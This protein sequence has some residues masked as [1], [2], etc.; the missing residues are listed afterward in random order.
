[1]GLADR[2]YRSLVVA[3]GSAVAIL[4]VIEYWD[5]DGARSLLSIL[6]IGALAFI[7][8]YL[9]YWIEDKLTQPK[10]K[11]INAFGE[12]L[13]LVTTKKWGPNGIEAEDVMRVRSDSYDGDCVNLAVSFNPRKVDRLEI[14]PI[15]RPLADSDG[16]VKDAERL[17]NEP[18]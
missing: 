17:A 6:G 8:T 1:M 13:L 3:F 18:F 10:K 9:P 14:S 7:L 12:V 2:I 5:S 16:I 4:Y 15:R 11:P